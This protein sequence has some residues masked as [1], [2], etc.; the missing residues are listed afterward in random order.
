M[1]RRGSGRTAIDSEDLFIGSRP[2][3]GILE[4]N[5]ANAAVS[6]RS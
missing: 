1:P 4:P 6:A 2:S 5:A 3:P